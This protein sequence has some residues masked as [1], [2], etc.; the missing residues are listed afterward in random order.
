L[1]ILFLNLLY[2][3]EIK[4]TKEYNKIRKSDYKSSEKEIGME[5]KLWKIFQN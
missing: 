4:I 5:V 3:I 1:E 2:Y